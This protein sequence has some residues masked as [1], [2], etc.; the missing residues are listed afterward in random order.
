MESESPPLPMDTPPVTSNKDLVRSSDDPDSL[1]V[2]LWKIIQLAIFTA[3]WI[4][5]FFLA[6]QIQSY[7]YYLSLVVTHN[8]YQ[9]SGHLVNLQNLSVTISALLALLYLFILTVN[10]R[11]PELQ[12]ENQSI[13]H[14][15]L[16]STMALF[17][18]LIPFIRFNLILIIIPVFLVIMMLAI[19]G[20][21]SNSLVRHFTWRIKASLMD[22][23][24]GRPVRIRSF[25]STYTMI[26]AIFASSMIILLVY[27]DMNILEITTQL[28]FFICLLAGLLLTTA[29][30]LL[31][32]WIN[33]ENDKLKIFNDEIRMTVGIFRWFLLTLV[34]IES[35]I[36]ITSDTLTID[37][38]LTLLFLVYLPALV[39]ELLFTRL[40]RMTTNTENHTISILILV[41]VLAGMRLFADFL[42]IYLPEDKVSEVQSKTSKL[43]ANKRVKEISSPSEEN[44]LPAERSLVSFSYV[45]ILP[46]EMA[47]IA[48]KIVFLAMFMMIFKFYLVDRFTF[49]HFYTIDGLLFFVILLH[50]YSAL[51][52]SSYKL[53]NISKSNDHHI[54]Q[55]V[56]YLLLTLVSWVA[57]LVTIFT[58]EIGHYRV[59]CSTSSI[60]GYC[61]P[62]VQDLI[63]IQSL[64]VITSL[65][66][67]IIQL[68]SGKKILF[69]PVINDSSLII[70]GKKSE[71]T[72]MLE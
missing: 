72:V 43:M 21:T 49:S 15:G 17:T 41:Y 34:M 26:S 35:T 63:I 53:H 30:I 38:I 28:T 13:V 71:K 36:I 47:I 6:G 12:S 64:I 22:Y 5:F 66:F 3:T 11:I 40:I 65:P 68:V 51:I 67:I 23:Y 50:V 54:M 10:V 37:S 24:E 16:L 55:P 18:I 59:Y 33:G 69:K 48:V 57:I 19:E 9:F 7:K 56:Y 8:N 14:Y 52:I 62:S 29:A 70:A 42:E 20:N 45:Y 61:L 60:L 1:K 44:P 46:K 27:L 58:F 39:V 4:E 31:D 2:S 25:V 32:I